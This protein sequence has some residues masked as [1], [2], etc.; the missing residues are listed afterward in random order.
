[1]KKLPKNISKHLGGKCSQS[2]IDYAKHSAADALKTASKR[3]IK[4]QQKQEVM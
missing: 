3:V 4:N 2:H 1:M